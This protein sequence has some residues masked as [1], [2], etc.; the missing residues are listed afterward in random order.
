ML[1]WLRGTP[2]AYGVEIAPEGIRFCEA[3][4]LTGIVRGSVS[5]LPFRGESFDIVLSLD[6]LYHEGVPDD[7]AAAREAA[8][9]LRPGG[10]LVMNLPAY[11]LLRGA[12]DRAIHTARRYTRSRVIRLLEAAGLRAERVTHWNALL[13]PAAAI[14]RLLSRRRSGDAAS[15]VHPVANPLN[16]ALAAILR[17]EAVWLSRH[18]LPVGLSVFAEARKPLGVDTGASGLMPD[19]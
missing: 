5:E 1:A 17:L 15:D 7:A 2:E 10:L 11:E 18:N 13:L 19:A 3:R 16:R 12:H 8:R 9:V 4:G 6:V 14:S